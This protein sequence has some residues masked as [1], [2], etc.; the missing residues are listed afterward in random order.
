M[1]KFSRL[2]AHLS[3]LAPPAAGQ[4]ETV[5]RAVL[6]FL[7]AHGCELHLPPLAE[8]ADILGGGDDALQADIF[9]MADTLSGETLGIR[10]DHTPQTARFD[11]AAGGADRR[12]CYCG[13][14]LR[15]RPPQPW[16]GREIMQIGAEIFNLPPPAA[17]WEIIRLACGALR[18]A[19][20]GDAA[21]DIGHAGIINRLLD[22]A[23][24][25]AH[26]AALFRRLARQDC[27]ALNQTPG[28]GRL[29]KLLETGGDL[30]KA[31]AVA[32]A[33]AE[34]ELADL[35]YVVR[36]L[37][38]E[39]FDAAVNFS[40]TG[41]Y[42]YH[43]GIVFSIYGGDFAAARGGRYGRRGF[44][45]AV[46]FS[47]DLREII[48]HLPPPPPPP[49]PVSCPPAEE[50]AWIDAVAG[51]QKQNRRIR[52]ATDKNPPPPVLEKSPAGVW[53]VRES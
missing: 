52:F 31:A 34:K 47:M 21:I 3:D 48:E 1:A 15:A 30:D 20:I 12:L 37:R 49:P 18:A 36:M 35:S 14:A 5:R 53:Q 9:K 19:G 2:P 38:L 45:P 24:A 33:D 22:G 6:D 4:L 16:K 44:R 10:A 51:L 46:G 28:G 29:V 25:A 17:D 11:A 39:N 40:E 32:D 8:Y 26:R 7:R 41:G 43:T 23:D 13:P 42:G 27:A 50:Q